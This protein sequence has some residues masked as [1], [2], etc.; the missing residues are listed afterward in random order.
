MVAAPAAGTAMNPHQSIVDYATAK[1]EDSWR[2]G[3]EA[4]R[5]LKRIATIGDQ[6]IV[7]GRVKLPHTVV[8]PT[9]AKRGAV[10]GG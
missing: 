10:R 1:G 6:P 2:V 4:T 8:R 9:G 7:S 5:A 3:I